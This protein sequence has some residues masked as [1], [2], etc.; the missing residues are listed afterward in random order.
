MKPLK[1]F[2]AKA[3]FKVEVGD[4]GMAVLTTD[5]QSVLRVPLKRD[6]PNI[7]PLAGDKRGCSSKIS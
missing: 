1:T 5:L 6:E 4:P 2:P 7:P 3:G